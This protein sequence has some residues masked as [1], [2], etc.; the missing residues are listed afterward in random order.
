MLHLRD[1]VDRFYKKDGVELR[2]YVLQNNISNAD[3]SYFHYTSQHF[4]LMNFKRQQEFNCYRSLN[5][6][7]YIFL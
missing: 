7:S 5:L 6:K 4:T 2:T 3:H 1:K